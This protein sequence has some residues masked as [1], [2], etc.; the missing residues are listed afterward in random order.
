M[1]AARNSFIGSSVKRIG[2]KINSARIRYRT[3]VM[4][5]RSKKSNPHD[6]L[7][8]VTAY[9]VG[10][11]GDTALSECVRQ[12]YRNETGFD[13]WRLVSVYDPVDDSLVDS[14]NQTKGVLIGGGGLF[15]P[16][17]NK[18]NLSGWQWAISKDLLKKIEVPLIVY[19]VGYNNFRGQEDSDLFVNSLNVLIQQAAFV[20]LRNHGSVEHVRALLEPSIKDKVIFQP[21]TTTIARRIYPTLPK[22]Q[23]HKAVAFNIA[24]DRA[25]RRYG[26][27]KDEILSQIA[28]AAIAIR[29]KGYIVYVIGHCIADL[30]FM[31]YVK[32][33]LENRESGLNGIKVVNASAWSCTQLLQFYNRIDC[34]IGMRGHAQMIPFGVNCHIIT[35]G[36]H[37]K[38][39][40]FLEDIDCEDWYIEITQDVDS[41]ANRIVD[42]FIQVH[43]NEN[44]NT[45]QRLIDE[46]NK[47]YNIT[48]E[49]MGVIKE[50]IGI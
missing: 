45:T 25:D 23:T 12:T 10:N 16:D 11:V 26:E 3:A 20:G 41:L 40:W 9:S 46:Q 47:L 6:S 32:Q 33:S 27:R 42:K 21:C 14:I 4:K 19:T 18:N 38:M 5:S 29:D 37:A 1:M 17:S 31:N 34:V 44:E 36:S 2:G 22:K 48:K 30:D 35:L 50:I 28:E 15:L 13:S 8:H 49:N 24:F 43:E 7:T 39:K